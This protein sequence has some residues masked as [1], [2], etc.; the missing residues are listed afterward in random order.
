[1]LLFFCSL[2]VVGCRLL[3]VVRRLLFVVH[4]LLVVVSCLLS[5]GQ[6]TLTTSCSGPAATIP[7]GLCSDVATIGSMRR[8]IDL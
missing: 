8:R 2:L 1:M 4:C 7:C 6:T 3:V 5:A